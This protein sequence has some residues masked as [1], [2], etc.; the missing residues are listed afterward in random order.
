MT[1]PYP[2]PAATPAND[3][4]T[5]FGVLGIVFGIC[6][7]I[8][9]IIFAVLSLNA[10]KKAGKPQTLAIIGF[11]VAAISIVLGIVYQVSN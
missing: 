5:L 4:T 2:P 10:A 9:G 3:R 6:C 7:P 1:T 11:V 8:V